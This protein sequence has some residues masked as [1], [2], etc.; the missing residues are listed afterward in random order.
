MTEEF[1]LDPIPCIVCGTTP[2]SVHRSDTLSD[3]NYPALPYRATMFESHGNHGSTVFDP[4][5]NVEALIANVCD[6]CLRRA[7]KKGRVYRVKTLNRVDERIV[8]LW[9]AP[10]K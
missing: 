2:E 3:S 9:R 6:D 8:S 5:N 7:S 4:L 10:K 1:S